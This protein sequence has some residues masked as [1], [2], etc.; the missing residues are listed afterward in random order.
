[1]APQQDRL[2]TVSLEGEGEAL[3]DR[4]L[5]RRPASFLLAVVLLAAG[6][7]ALGLALATDGRKFVS[8][9]EWQG[10]PLSPALPLVTSRAFAPASAGSLGAGLPPPGVGGAGGPPPLGGGAGPGGPRGT[11]RNRRAVLRLRL[12]LSHRGRWRGRGAGRRRAAVRH[13]VRRV[14]ADGL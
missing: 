9:H 5:P 1:L 11:R 2:Q 8:S 4:W 3:I 7:W 14:A 10:P 13:V 6:C 12:P